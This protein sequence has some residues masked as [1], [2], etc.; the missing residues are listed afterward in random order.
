MAVIPHSRHRLRAK[1]A[2]AATFAV[3]IIA[4]RT[5]RADDW[6][7]WRGPNRD[8][9]YNETG[10]LETFPADGLKVLW[11][12]PVGWGFSSPVVVQGRVFLSDAELDDPNVK[13][14]VLCFDEATGKPLW[15]YSQ[16]E[17]YPD[18]EF[19]PGQ[20]QGPNATPVVVD[21]KVYAL[22]PMGHRLFCLDAGGGK[23]LWKK[24]LEQEYEIASS[25]AIC[26]S[27]LIE[28]K[29]L[30]LLIGG[31]P[32]AG[33]VALDKDSGKEVWRSL[34]E[35]VAH[36]SPIVITAGGA[37]QLIVWTLKSVTSLDP[38]TGQ[39]YWQE[40]FNSGGSASVVSTP[41][42][43]DN[44]L[45]VNGLMLKLD[46]EKPSAAVVWPE[47]PRHRLLSSTSTALWRGDYL[48]CC[49]SSG[50]LVCREASTG[51]EIWQSD[52]AT[53]SGYGTKASLH[54]TINGD[55]VLLFND[56][57]ELIRARLT[58]EGY[59]EI[60]RVPLIEPTYAF[61]GRKAAWSAPSFA[62]RHV[63]ARNDKEL[64]CSS[65]AAE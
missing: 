57:G 41:V 16:V 28:G 27:P 47:H 65:L 31:K 62:N 8:G 45:L 42:F 12:V 64:I 39:P 5:A 34:D 55:S 17:G 24:D 51:K 6:P 13:E 37:R 19:K 58:S 49:E 59:H 7:Q 20:E 15:T 53:D 3:L 61:G 32:D 22:G 52:K 4:T 43:S 10:V 40:K 11:R 14:R 29:L 46:A 56:L 2:A 33:V 63:F 48:Y 54:L 35:Y 44:R 9:V 25:T 30:I 50:Q 38:A 23:L 36:S 18:W 60:S 26:A 1:L 21:G